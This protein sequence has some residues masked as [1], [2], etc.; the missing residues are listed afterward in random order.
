MEAFYREFAGELDFVDR[1][2][3]FYEIMPKGVSKAS[4]IRFLADKLHIPMEDTVAIGDSNNDIPM[5]QCAHT[6]IAMGNA[7]KAVLDMADYVTDD[8][9]K[10][11][12]QKALQWI[13]AI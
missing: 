13:G 5:L 4:G 7:S 3:G 1:E 10:G 8:V 12:I 11:G 2:K 9:N 6:S